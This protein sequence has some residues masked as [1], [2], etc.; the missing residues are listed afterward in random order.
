MANKVEQQLS[1]QQVDALS[2]LPLVF[3]ITH[4]QSKHWP[5]THAIS[6]VHAVDTHTI[7]FAIEAD[8]HLVTTLKE[9][10]VF[11][12]IFFADQSTYS[13]TCTD[14]ESFTPKQQLPIPLSFYE[15][16]VEEVRDILFYGA[17]ITQ[18]PRIEK[19]YDE[20]AADRL[21]Q[22]V[23]HILKESHSSQTRL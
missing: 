6:W 12:L 7:R 21:D 18:Q 2:Q 1:P 23:H 14:V 13:L 8:S 11:T 22:S 15:G 20:K 10:P 9:H 16:R 19:T 3:L 4:D 5:I 17:A